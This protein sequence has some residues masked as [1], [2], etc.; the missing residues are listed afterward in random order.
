MNGERLGYT[1]TRSAA[2]TMVKIDSFWSFHATD[3]SGSLPSMAARAAPVACARKKHELEDRSWKGAET[4]PAGTRR[5]KHVQA[6]GSRAHA[7]FANR[8]AARRSRPLEA[9]RACVGSLGCVRACVRAC[10]RVWR[11]CA[12]ANRPWR[13]YFDPLTDLVDPGVVVQKPYAGSKRPAELKIEVREESAKASAGGAG[14]RKHWGGVRA[15]AGRCLRARAVRGPCTRTLL[16]APCRRCACAAMTPL[17]A[18][19]W[20]AVGAAA[21][22]MGARVPWDHR[23]ERR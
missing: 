18:C 8:S 14:A 5:A 16:R 15:N 17:V 2:A 4:T 11:A 22:V 3:V 6:S 13:D 10:V 23:G 21:G 1:P 19:S 9:W 7:A 12:Q 20:R